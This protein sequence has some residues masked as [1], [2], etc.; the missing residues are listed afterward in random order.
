MAFDRKG[1]D[2]ASGMKVYGAFAT[3]YLGYYLAGVLKTQT[4]DYRVYVFSRMTEPA[5]L[6]K[7]VQA[8]LS[9]GNLEN[10]K[11]TD[12]CRS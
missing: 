8:Y 10:S 11:A 6:L 1:A 5:V 2:Y 3:Q 9:S 12:G 4:E 7:Q